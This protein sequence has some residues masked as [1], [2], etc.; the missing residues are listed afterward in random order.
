[1]TLAHQ[2]GDNRSS[3]N[4]FLQEISKLSQINIS[5]I[6]NKCNY[7]V[8]SKGQ[9]T[10]STESLLRQHSSPQQEIN[11]TLVEPE[12]IATPSR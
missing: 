12:S 9:T 4:S 10:D 7:T 2:Y 1:S 3:K 5:R 8:L 6:S 11:T